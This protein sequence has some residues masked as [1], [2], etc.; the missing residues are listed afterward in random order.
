MTHQVE[1]PDHVYQIAQRAAAREG[2]T[3][4]EWIA[5]TV[6]RAGAPVPA[7]ENPGEERPTRELLARYIGAFDSSRVTPDPQYRTEF[8]DIVAE[9]LRRQGLDI[10]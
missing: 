1:I 9:K 5:A 2:I 10:P 8:G 3:P 7:D 4:A 6:S